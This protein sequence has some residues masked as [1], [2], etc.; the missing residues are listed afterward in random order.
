MALAELIT[1]Q[2]I[3]PRLATRSLDMAGG[4]LGSPVVDMRRASWQA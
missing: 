2:A 1:R 4:P 3:S